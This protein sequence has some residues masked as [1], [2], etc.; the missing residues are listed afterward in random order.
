MHWNLYIGSITGQWLFSLV[1]IF[2]HIYVISFDK[3]SST[4]SIFSHF[5]PYFEEQICHTHSEPL[6]NK[7]SWKINFG[8]ALHRF[9]ADDLCTNFH[10]FPRKYVTDISKCEIIILSDLSNISIKKMWIKLYVSITHEYFLD[11][12]RSHKT[13][14]NVFS[15]AWFLH[16][17]LTKFSN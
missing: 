10:Q 17:V 15:N 3:N 2:S 12:Q 7:S 14:A 5:C 6:S 4:C 1:M 13:F 8:P 16:K 9:L 11:F